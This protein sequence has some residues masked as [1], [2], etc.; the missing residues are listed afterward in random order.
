MVFLIIEKFQ[1]DIIKTER[2]IQTT[3]VILTNFIFGNLLNNF[4]MKR[5]FIF[6]LVLLFILS[7][8]SCDFDRRKRLSGT[9]FEL[10]DST[11]PNVELLYY[12]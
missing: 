12:G 2:F 7:T 5:I 11:V 1:K 3:L 9:N 8:T 10:G 6:P 4:C